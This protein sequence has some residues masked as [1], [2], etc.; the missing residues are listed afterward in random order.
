MHLPSDK[1]TRLLPRAAQTHQPPTTTPSL[2]LGSERVALN[3]PPSGVLADKLKDLFVKAHSQGIPKE[4]DPSPPHAYTN[5]VFKDASSTTHKTVY[6][7]AAL[8]ANH[9]RRIL[10]HEI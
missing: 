10:T 1:A 5:R 6:A 4:G 7:R 2:R 9:P 3:I 8:W